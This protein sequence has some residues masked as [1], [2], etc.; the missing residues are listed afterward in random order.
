[1]ETEMIQHTYYYGNFSGQ[2]IT[3]ATKKQKPLT[4]ALVVQVSGVAGVTLVDGFETERQARSFAAREGYTDRY[5][6]SY[7][8]I[9]TE[10]PSAA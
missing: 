2:Q 1:M 4:V 10:R 7:V 8:P 3:L 9:S 5:A 6:C